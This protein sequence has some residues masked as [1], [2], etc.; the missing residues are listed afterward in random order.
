MFN[1]VTSGKNITSH[2]SNNEVSLVVRKISLKTIIVQRISNNA[3]V[4]IAC[5]SP[6]ETTSST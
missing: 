4:F 5:P 3:M 6:L 2:F 1:I